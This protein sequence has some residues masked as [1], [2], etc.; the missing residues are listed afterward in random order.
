MICSL[1]VFKAHFYIWLPVGWNTLTKIVDYSIFKD[2]SSSIYYTISLD[3]MVYLD[4]P[5]WIEF[6]DYLEIM[7]KF[8]S[9]GRLTNFVGKGYFIL[10]LALFMTS[11]TGI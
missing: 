8:F 3:Y 7:E 4:P 9:K 2:L 5:N 6:W 1:F 11:F 10:N